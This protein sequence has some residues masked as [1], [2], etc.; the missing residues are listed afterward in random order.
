MALL[1][2]CGL[3][4]WLTDM[5]RTLLPVAILSIILCLGTGLG[6]L[7]QNRTLSDSEKN[8]SQNKNVPSPSPSPSP[9][10]TPQ[11][12][13]PPDQRERTFDEVIKGARLVD[14]DCDGIS[15]AEDNC[16]AVRNTDQKDTD[17][18][19][20]GDACQQQLN[21]ATPSVRKCQKTRPKSKGSGRKK[22]RTE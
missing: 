12:L 19:G 3:P 11:P 1:R 17:G 20:I 21:R 18:N 5:T 9:S 16:P 4:T 6:G 22:R 7:S 8:T 15:N 2:L 14:T 10:P 13:T